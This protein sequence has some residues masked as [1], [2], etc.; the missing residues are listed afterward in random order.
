M[1]LLQ[2]GI[3]KM[4]KEIWRGARVRRTSNPE[5]LTEYLGVV[6]RRKLLEILIHSY[7]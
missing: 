7:T 1:G 4:F 3:N 2:K 5:S 6:A